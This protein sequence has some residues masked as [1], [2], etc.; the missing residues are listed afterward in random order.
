MKQ[1]LH[2]LP[3]SA[4]GVRPLWRN[5]DFLIAG[6]ARFVATAGMGAVVVSVML[7]LQNAAA[8]GETPVAGP[9]LVAAY[10]LCSALPLVLLAPWAGRLADTMDSRTLR[11]RFV[12]GLITG[13]RVVWPILSG[14]LVLI[15]AAGVVAGLIEGWSVQ[16]SIYFA[17][18]SGLTIGYGDL[19][20]KSLLGR[21]LA[22][23]IGVCGVLV[24]ALVAAIA[25]KALTA[26]SDDRE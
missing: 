13:L 20:P 21:V 9:W 1:T 16:E 11:K 22:I 7:H 2:K 23:G 12:G 26:A 8:A 17:F 4:T 25:V 10:L 6:T 15:V 18:V 5:R 19:A 3:A 24:T 14:L